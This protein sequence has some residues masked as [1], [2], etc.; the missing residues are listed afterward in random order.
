M[1]APSEIRRRKA[2]P[3]R[4][5]IL[6]IVL[7][8]ALVLFITSL[9]GLAGFYTD[10]LWFDSLGFSG[11][12]KRVLGAKIALALIFTGIFFV[13][14]WVNLLIADRIAPRFRPAG[15]EEEFIER[16]H[17]LI[18]RRTGLVRIIVSL[19]FGL[20]AG[21]GTS[22]QWND[23][24][25]FTH[26]VDFGQKDP[27]FH[28]D[29]GFYVFRLPFLRFL[30]NWLF[31]SLLIVMIITAVAHYLNGGIRV[32]TPGQRV[33]PQV[34]AHLSVL[35]AALALV[36]ARRLLAPALRPHL[37]DAGLRRRCHLHRREG[38]AAG[39]QPADPHLLRRGHLA[40]RQ[41]LPA[42]LGA[43]GDRG[44]PVGIRR[45]GR[46]RGLPGVH[47]ALPGAAGGV[48]QGAPYIARNIA[49]TRDALGV[50]KVNTQD[51]KLTQ[52]VTS[53]D[54]ATD[55]PTLTNMRLLDPDIVLPTF[56]QLQGI[57][58]FYQFNDLD[59]DRYMIDGQE[60]QVVLGVRE[61]NSSDLPQDTWEGRHLAYTHGYGLA[62]ARR[63][64]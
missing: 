29:V 52:D 63:T 16:Y 46:R 50:D 13:L 4:G 53:A 64:R 10:Y 33:T 3:N 28:T 62:A 40:D 44:R 26:R 20:I 5:R 38:A 9:R 43:A 8:I 56:Q 11:V 36:K 34:K 25:L 30:V 6:L 24:I 42:G 49:A 60:R 48:D 14:C 58:S 21:V 22:S 35:L 45:G 47:P 17:E 2:R 1:R 18:G 37:L 31:A 59:V 61:L 27:L 32:Q 19:L 7:A 12:F 54:L 57:R 51:F 15:P 55:D 41:H 23:W 39:D